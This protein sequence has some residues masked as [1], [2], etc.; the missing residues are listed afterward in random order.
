MM[1]KIGE[2]EIKVVGKSGNH[3]LSS[4]NYEI[5]HIT[6]ILQNV[7]DL[8]YPN[9]Q[10]DRL[11]IT[12]NIHEGSNLHI[13]KTTIQAVIG[14]S[15]VL[16]QVQTNESIDFLELKT[17]RAIENIQNLSRQKNY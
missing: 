3:D 7:E 6:T 14:F 5:K 8:L 12:Y 13:F 2:I 17:V 10:K 16:T 1:E 15:A 11:I 9:N 4:D